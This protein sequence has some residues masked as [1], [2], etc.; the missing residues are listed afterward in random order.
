MAQNAGYLNYRDY[1]WQQLFRFDY[2]PQDCKTF[3]AAVEQVVVPAVRRAHEK[4]LRRL[5]LE[6]LR[7]WDLMVDPLGDRKPHLIKDVPTFLKQCAVAFGHADPQLRAYF[8]EMLEK[9]LLDLEKRPNKAHGGYNLPLE[10]KRLPF[11]FGRV[12]TINDG[13]TLVFHEAGHAF[14]VFEMRGLPYVH[15]HKENFLPME[16]AEVASTSMECIGRQHIVEA[17]LCDSAEAARLRIRHLEEWFITFLF[18]TV[19]HGDAFQHW[20]YE[21]PDRAQDPEQCDQQWVELGKRFQPGVDWSGL[22]ADECSGWQQIPH[23]FAFPFY[24]IEYAFA[25]IGALQIWQNYLRD[26]KQ[27]IEQYRY[28]LS[29]GASRPLP[30]LFAA[31]GARFAFGADMLKEL[32]DLMEKMII[33]LE[34][35][36]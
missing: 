16:F 21:N 5:G 1:R 32:M 9:D 29:L 19:A 15:Q 26:P 18:P 14:H 2:T 13:V 35:S 7:P 36:L 34:A 20:V 23:F 22:E 27:A 10:I 8:E 17:G 28:A 25:T 24:F 4:R 31:A 12:H 3:H 33:E 6:K 11:I 30:E